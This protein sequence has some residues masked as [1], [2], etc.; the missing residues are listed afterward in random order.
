MNVLFLP[1]WYP[2][3]EN[4]VRGIFCQKSAEAIGNY[5]HLTVLTITPCAGLEKNPAGAESVE[6]DTQVMRIYYKK[7]RFIFLGKFIDLSRLCFLAIKYFKVLRKDRGNFDVVHAQEINPMG[8]AALVLNFFYK[9][10]YVLTLHWS[11]YTREDGS[12]WGKSFLVRFF[13]KLVLDK[14]SLLTTVSR[15]LKESVSAITGNSN[16]VVIGNVAERPVHVLD[17]KPDNGIHLLHVSLLDDRQKNV[18]G[19]IEVMNILKNDAGNIRLD[20]VGSGKDEA[21]LKRLSEDLGLRDHSVFFHGLVPHDQ[22]SAFYDHADIFIC[23]S[24]FE[25]FSVACAEALMHGVPV[26]STRC[27]GPEDFITD[28]AGVL[29][30]LREPKKLAA[31]LRLMISD[32]DGYDRAAIRKYAE[33][34]FA[35]GKIALEYV[36]RY[37]EVTRDRYSHAKQIHSR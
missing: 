34:L 9:M 25:T 31:A 7:S 33:S 26:V 10:P 29:V 1:S 24:N 8:L 32:L 30:P 12:F 14:S 15:Y 3:K 18:S 27:G 36:K 5:A 37:E 35:P 20:I 17:G 22:V 21:K 19:I 23:N 28:Q 11:G 2:D 16:L 4:P 13:Y 6:K